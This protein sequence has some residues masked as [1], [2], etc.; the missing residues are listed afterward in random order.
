MFAQSYPQLIV[1]L[2]KSEILKKVIIAPLILFMMSEVHDQSTTGNDSCAA[3]G[4][5]DVDLFNPGSRD[6]DN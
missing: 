6:T 3:S 1:G 4:V 2:L 5:K